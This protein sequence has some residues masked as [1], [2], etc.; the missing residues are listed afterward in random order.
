MVV[1]HFVSG[2]GGAKFVSIFQMCQFLGP[3]AKQLPKS[4][5]HFLFLAYLLGLTPVTKYVM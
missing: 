5:V 1:C 2:D 3:L 4:R